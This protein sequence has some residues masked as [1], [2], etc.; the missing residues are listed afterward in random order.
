MYQS[1]W[2]GD[3]KVEQDMTNVATVLLEALEASR[4][5][6]RAIPTIPF[7]RKSVQIFTVDLSRQKHA[8]R[9]T[10]FIGHSMG[11]LVIAKAITIADSRRR[12]YPVLFEAITTTIF[13]GTPFRGAAP[14]SVAS[15]FAYFA[16]KTGK[17]IH[18]ELLEFS[19]SSPTPKPSL[20]ASQ[21]VRAA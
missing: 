6:V 1:Q 21:G 12:D 3:W 14:A 15:M 16:S 11:G 2:Q 9:P 7:V 17:A 4:G 20:H 13:F 19:R 10:V 8:R 5:K 18:S